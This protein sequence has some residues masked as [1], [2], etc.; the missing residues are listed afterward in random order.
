MRRI[1]CIAAWSLGTAIAILLISAFVQGVL[2]FFSAYWHGEVVHLK[3]FTAA[4]ILTCASAVFGATVLG[5]RG[6]L[7]GTRRQ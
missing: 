4:V 2:A 6:K 1:I 5:L 3:G 7:P